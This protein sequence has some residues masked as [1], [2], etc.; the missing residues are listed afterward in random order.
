MGVKV[1]PAAYQQMVQYVTKNCPQ[2]RPYIDEILSS[3]GSKV[4]DPG[5]LTLEQKQEPQTLQKYFEAHYEDSCKI[6][7]ALEEA[8]LTV[9]PLRIA[10]KSPPTVKSWP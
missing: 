8:Q 4:I 1:G 7:D 3:T 5:K 2:S 6:F 9:K 10:A